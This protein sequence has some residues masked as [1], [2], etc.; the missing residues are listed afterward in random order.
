MSLSLVPPSPKPLSLPLEAWLRKRAT[1]TTWIVEDIIPKGGLVNLFA[2]PKAG[3]SFLALDL[4]LALAKGAKSW[5]IFDIVEPGPVIYFQLDTPSMLWRERYWDLQDAGVDISTNGMMRE[6]DREMV[7]MPFDIMTPGSYEVIRNE[8]ACVKPVLVIIDTIREVHNEDE[9]KS[10]EMKRVVA[11]LQMACAPSAVLVI[12]HTRKRQSNSKSKKGAEEKGAID[13]PN[14]TDQSRGSGYLAGKAD[15]LMW[16][17]DNGMLMYKGRAF[18]TSHLNLERNESTVLWELNQTAKNQMAARD[19]V[20]THWEE[21]QSGE[22][23]Q[24]SLARVL[25]ASTKQLEASAKTD[26]HRQVKRLRKEEKRR[27]RRE[28]MK[29]DEEGEAMAV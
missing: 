26:I 28:Q 27:Q 7:E 25:I 4:A 12:S 2:P 17:M 29:L 13:L 16:L 18:E 3:K 24:A 5:L 19:L 22:V 14:I 1:E 6:I 23:T 15:T 11:T 9:D 21:I 8:I 20:K 10:G